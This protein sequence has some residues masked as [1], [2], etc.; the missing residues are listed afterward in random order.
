MSKLVYAVA[1]A[2]LVASPAFAQS[3]DPSVGSG[4]IAPQ[5]KSDPALAAYAQHLRAEMG[6]RDAVRS[7]QPVGANEKALFDRIPKE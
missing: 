1:F 4:N 3:Y 6:R 5:V 2:G 7:T